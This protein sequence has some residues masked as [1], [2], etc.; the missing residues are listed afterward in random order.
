MR[1]VLAA[2]A[3]SGA[4]LV[5]FPIFSPEGDFITQQAKEGKGVEQI[6]LIGADGLLTSTFIEAVGADGVGYVFCRA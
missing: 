5:F 1:P 3:A 4:E 6:I 2:V